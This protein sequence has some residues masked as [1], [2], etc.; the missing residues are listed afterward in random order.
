MFF[1]FGIS[2]FQHAF[3]YWDN[4]LQKMGPFC[5]LRKLAFLSR[6]QKTVSGLMAAHAFLSLPQANPK[7][8]Q[9]T[10]KQTKP[11][12][13]QTQHDPNQSQSNTKPT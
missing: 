7:P 11:N 12:P 4:S 5:E 8:P 10:P 9:P 3:G 13:K 1:D 2:C 6:G